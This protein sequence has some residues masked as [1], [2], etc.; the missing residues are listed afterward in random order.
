M[1]RDA[2]FQVGNKVQT[3]SC[4]IGELTSDS[5][6]LHRDRIVLSTRCDHSL[7]SG[8][9]SISYYDSALIC[10]CYWYNFHYR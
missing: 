2:D 10:H 6:R 3:G 5:S 9:C 7:E 8:V 4:A 1:K